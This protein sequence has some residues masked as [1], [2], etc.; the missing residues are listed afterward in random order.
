MDM[1]STD[2]PN[3]EPSMPW[4]V[5]G[6]TVFGVPAAIAMYLVWAL[7]NSN[8]VALSQMSANLE[9]QKTAIAEVASVTRVT[10]LD[11]KE[12][13]LRVESYLRLLCVNTAKSF[14]DRQTCLTVR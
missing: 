11:A 7:V 8:T 2:S 10:T 14:A 12:S 1:T 13:A 6:I 5:R 9:A 3:A 4:W